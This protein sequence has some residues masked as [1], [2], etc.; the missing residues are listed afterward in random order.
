MIC[1]KKATEENLNDIVDILNAAT[2][3]LLAKG[4]MQWEYPWDKNV[5]GED[6]EKGLFYIATKDEKP[7]GCF[8]LK[9]FENNMF[10]CDNSGMYFYHLAVYPDY[11][12]KKYS[13]QM[14][15]FVQNFARE[16]NITVYF[17]CWA[18]NDFLKKFYSD[19]DFEY[20]GDFPEE[21]YFVSA[22]KTR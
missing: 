4:V 3:K 5:I 16:N 14:C 19:V 1:I 10:N 13:I 6:I 18:G 8:G 11:S 9:S 22:F 7:V 20:M 17:D 15:Q 21:D 2:Q 12:G